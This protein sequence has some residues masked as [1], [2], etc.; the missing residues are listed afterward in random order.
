MQC[1]NFQMSSKLCAICYVYIIHITNG[2]QFGAHLKILYML[3]YCIDA[4]L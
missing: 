1:V 2:T 4:H 3:V